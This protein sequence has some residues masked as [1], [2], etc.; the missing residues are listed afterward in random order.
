MA[1][2][3]LRDHGGQGLV[4]LKLIEIYEKNRCTNPK[5]WTRYPKNGARYPK[6]GA[7]YPKNGARYPKNGAR[8]LKNGTLSPKNGSR[9][10][11][12]GAWFPKNGS[13]YPRS[14]VSEKRNS[15]ARFA[16]ILVAIHRSFTT[17]W[18]SSSQWKNWVSFSH[19]APSRDGKK[20][21]L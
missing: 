7:P 8:Y 19:K 11:K 20:E 14:L 2:N 3:S 10:P 13:R 4:I 9:Y 6:N 1:S 5:N 12:N 18:A 15:D 17:A 21:A 16:R